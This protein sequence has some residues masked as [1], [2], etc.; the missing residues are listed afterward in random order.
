MI[1]QAGNLRT[2]VSFPAWAKSIWVGLDPY[3]QP[4]DT[5]V[6]EYSCHM[7]Y[8]TTFAGLFGAAACELLTQI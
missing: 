4:T 8:H 2:L 7:S 5:E 3:N 6:Y 1:G